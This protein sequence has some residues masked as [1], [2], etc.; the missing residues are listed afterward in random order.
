M[1]VGESLLVLVD[2]APSSVV[3]LLLRLLGCLVL[4][5]LVHGFLQR[6]RNVERLAGVVSLAGGFAFVSAGHGS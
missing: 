1:H 5:R 3:F 6:S 4:R 2:G